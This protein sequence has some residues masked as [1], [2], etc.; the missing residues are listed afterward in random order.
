[1]KI[2]VRFEVDACLPQAPSESSTRKAATTTQSTS[3][4]TAASSTDVDSLT[5]IMLGLNVSS[6][7]TTTTTVSPPSQAS[8]IAVI[9][10]GTQVPQSSIIEL[11][12]RSEKYI[13]EFSWAEQYPQLLLSY[14]PHLFL[15][16]HNRGTFERMIAHELGSD[17]LRNIENNTRVQRSFRQLAATLRAIQTLVKEHGQRGRLTLLC[18][19]D[20]TL[21]V[22]ERNTDQGVLPDIELDRFGV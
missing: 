8:D 3:Q 11:T 9:H 1:M 6:T 16:A 15:A 18:Q 14:T 13:D 17:E 7:T 21:E 10:A 5:D 12:T 4:R 22:H 19:G 20:G 2:V